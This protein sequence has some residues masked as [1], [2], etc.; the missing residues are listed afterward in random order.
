[1]I[2]DEKVQALQLS[3]VEQGADSD[4][5]LWWVAEDIRQTMPGASEKEIRSET[6]RVLRPVL[7]SGTLR[8][9]DLLPGGHFQPWAGSVEEQ[10]ARIDQEWAQLEAPPSLGD[11]VWFIGPRQ[12]QPTRD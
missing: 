6:L 4:I 9:V 3:W 11:I 10:L 2:N 7:K 8:A 12:Q 1:M 5:G